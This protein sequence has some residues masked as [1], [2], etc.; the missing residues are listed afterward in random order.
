MFLHNAAYDFNNNKNNNMNNSHEL[1]WDTAV[2]TDQTITAN[3]LDI[4]WDIVRIQ[5]TH[6]VVSKTNRARKI[7]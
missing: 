2:I 5:R 7:V 3:G 4:H 6:P 1:Q